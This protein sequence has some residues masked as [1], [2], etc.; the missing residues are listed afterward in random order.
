MPHY[1]GGNRQAPLCLYDM[2]CCGGMSSCRSG[3]QR[4]TSRREC[5][6]ARGR[7]ALAR[8]GCVGEVRALLTAPRLLSHPNSHMQ[9][10]R[11][12]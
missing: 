12:F 4:G 7:G 1:C 6:T 8:D 9:S 3:A 5:L 2:A 11:L 10:P